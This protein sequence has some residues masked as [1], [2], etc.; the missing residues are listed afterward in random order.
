MN[1]VSFELLGKPRERL[2]EHRK[3]NH[4]LAA[5]SA[6]FVCG[7]QSIPGR[8]IRRKTIR[9]PPPLIKW[10]PIE[11][12]VEFAAGEDVLHLSK[13]VPAQR[14]EN[15][16]RTNRHL[17]GGDRGY[18]LMRATQKGCCCCTPIKWCFV[19]RKYGINKT[20]TLLGSTLTPNTDTSIQTRETTTHAR[21]YT[22]PH[23]R[24]DY[25]KKKQNQKKKNQKQQ[26]LPS[27]ITYIQNAHNIIIT[28]VS[29]LPCTAL[30]A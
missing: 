26:H 19:Y 6:R 21:H 14:V 25:R 2:G 24:T 20:N 30:T 8:R 27:A 28:S 18:R 11:H 17:K 23:A 4:F 16:L 13:R 15:L 9:I 12:V 29:A 3:H 1:F 22:R 7:R 5:K 10:L